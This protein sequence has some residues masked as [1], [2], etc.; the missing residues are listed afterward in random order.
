M[1]SLNQE[2]LF[3]K[4]RI[5]DSLTVEALLSEGLNTDMRDECG[6]TPLHIAAKGGHTQVAVVLLNFNAN[7]CL[8]NYTEMTPLFCAAQYGHTTVAKRLVEATE[9][10][11]YLI[12]EPDE[13]GITPLVA[14]AT[15][16]ETS[17][18]EYL[19]SCEE[20]QVDATDNSGRTALHAAVLQCEQGIISMLLMAGAN[21]RTCDHLLSTPLMSAAVRG[22][23]SVIESLLSHGADVNV[24]SHE[25]GTALQMAVRM[26]FVR[27]AQILIEAGA[28]LNV[29]DNI[30]NTPVMW[31]TQFGR[32]VLADVLIKAGCDVTCRDRRGRT[33]LHHAAFFGWTDI[34]KHLLTEG[35]DSSAKN[36][37][38]FTPIVLAVRNNHFHVVKALLDTNCVLDSARCCSGRGPSLLTLA[39]ERGRRE[40]CDLLYKAGCSLARTSVQRI[41]QDIHPLHPTGMPDMAWIDDVLESPRSLLN[42]CRI[43]IRNHLGKDL[44]TEVKCLLVPKSVQEFILLDDVDSGDALNHNTFLG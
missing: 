3:A 37:A 6:N 11:F 5:G 22:S 42:C 43:V 32:D 1:D 23:E 21:P 13:N 26:N 44:R 17:M 31:A 35:L 15:H 12:N 29:H 7:T 10:R 8:V 18:V 40:V 36:G 34:V 20:L 24:I 25:G 39:L 30:G 9:N 14:A 16:G 4:S 33:L 28:N 2:L 27:V 38:G 41:I 19:L